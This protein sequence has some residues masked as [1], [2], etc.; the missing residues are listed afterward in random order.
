MQAW[1]SRWLDGEWIRPGPIL[2]LAAQVNKAFLRAD[3]AAGTGESLD[4]QVCPLS[5]MIDIDLAN[6]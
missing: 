6:G 5:Q 3:K 2:E 4:W 1:C